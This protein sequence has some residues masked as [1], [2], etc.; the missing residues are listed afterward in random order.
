MSRERAPTTY[1][2]Q[3]RHFPHN[4]C[5]FNVSERELAAIAERWARDQWIE[6]GERRWRPG[7]A[8][9]TILAGPTLAVTQLTMGRGWRAAER[10]GE[11]VT[12]RVLAS[13]SRSAV[14]SSAGE[15]A[16]GEPRAATTSSGEAPVGARTHA[17]PSEEGAAADRALLADS[18][19][20]ELLE[21]LDRGDEPLASAWSLAA[22][23]A[24]RGSASDSLAL[25]EL[26]VRSL[27]DR[28]LVSLTAGAPEHGAQS[29]QAAGVADGAL[30]V[31]AV[32]AALRAPESWADDRAATRRFSLRRS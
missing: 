5:R 22:E 3:L 30:S 11:D 10:S 20:L 7:E 4:H 17:A 14:G 28:G 25:A 16:G 29:S 27:L 18:V 23:R 8:Q 2:V 13:A 32:D 31:D 15:P 9:L 19:G 21:L 1:H 12:A 26:A 24:A 6:F